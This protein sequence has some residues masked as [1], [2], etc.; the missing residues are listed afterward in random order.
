MRLE[1]V[2]GHDRIATARYLQGQLAAVAVLNI[3]G[4]D[5]H[6]QQSTVRIGQDV[7]FAPGDLLA[8]IIAFSAPF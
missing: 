8:C 7:P 1:N 2:P 6:R 3:A 5:P 4:M